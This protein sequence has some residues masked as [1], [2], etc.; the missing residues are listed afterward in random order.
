MNIP[1]LGSLTPHSDIPEWLV[2]KPL[3]IPYFDG[4]KLTLTLD[5]LDSTDERKANTTIESFLKLSA[6]DRIAASPYVFKNYQRIAD[7]AYEEDLGCKIASNRD[8]WNHVR[9]SEIFVRRRGQDQTIYVQISAEC[10]WE[11]EHGLQ[12]VY[13]HGRMLSRVSAQDGHLTHS[14]AYGLPEDQDRIA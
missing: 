7:L 3:A 5:G 6:E 10:D 14:D 4:L 12:I 1:S 13:R 9:P 2:S 8:V 11:P